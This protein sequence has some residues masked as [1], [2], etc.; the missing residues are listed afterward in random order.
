MSSLNT[1]IANKIK[2][3]NCGYDCRNAIKN[4][5]STPGNDSR[6]I[7]NDLNNKSISH[8]RVKNLKNIYI[9]IPCV[10]SY[11]F[12]RKYFIGIE[13]FLWNR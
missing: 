5:M 8:I 4:H 11:S 12:Q 13:A 6:L 2:P 7:G 10:V 1:K 9:S 3:R